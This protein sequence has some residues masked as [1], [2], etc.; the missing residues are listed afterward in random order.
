MKSQNIESGL[1]MLKNSVVI[2][3]MIGA[4]LA[5]CTSTP[6]VST[7]T[8]PAETPTEFPL[9]VATDTPE[10]TET[11]TPAP[12]EVVVTLDP[13]RGDYRTCVVLGEH[14]PLPD[15]AYEDFPAAILDYLNQGAS[16]EELAVELIVRE[17]GP[18]EQ[19]VRADDLTADGFQDVVVTIYDLQT[20][21]QGGMLIYTCADGAYVLSYISLAEAAEQAPEALMIQD[22]DADEQP[23]L[24]FATTSCGAHTCFNDIEIL[25]WVDGAFVE[26]VEGV[27]TAL[28]NPT[29]QLTDYD[30]DAIYTLEVVGTAFAS[31]G[32]GPQR[33]ETWV[34]ELDLADGIWKFATSSLAVSPFRIHLVHDADD[35]MLR[36]EYQI[37]FLLYAQVVEDEDLLDWNN[38]TQEALNLGAYAYF[39]RV[40]A[41]GYLAQIQQG[42]TLLVEMVELYPDY[43]QSAYVEMAQAFW[44]A[45][46][47]SGVVEDGCAAAHQYAVLNQSAVLAPLGSITYGYANRDY[48]P[49]DICP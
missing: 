4:L 49:T 12:T 10:L 46:T 1:V 2:L 44:T 22:L 6:A 16:P 19:P 20:E 38:P 5:G 36:G 31:V 7:P 28:P 15:M 11:E 34:W 47:T 13:G 30:R 8:E 27:T 3:F 29:A 18:R 26:R 40:V 33:D 17:L 25:S 42:E 32:A 23:D 43:P 14:D 9:E 24:V 45:F 41:A 35:A 21:S 37:A 39:K 48:G